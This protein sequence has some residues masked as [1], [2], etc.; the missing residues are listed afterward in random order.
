[1][2]ADVR[3][4]GGWGGGGGR[5]PGFFRLLPRAASAR[6]LVLTLRAGGGRGGLPAAAR[7]PSFWP[8]RQAQRLAG[9]KALGELQAN[10]QLNCYSGTD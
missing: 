6:R 9:G 8:T 3:I 7:T 5:A 10:P 2:Y 1:M 4:F